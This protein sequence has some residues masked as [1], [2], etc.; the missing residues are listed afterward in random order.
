MSLNNLLNIFSKNSRKD[1]KRP[2]DLAPCGAITVFG[3][4]HGPK[5]SLKAARH[6][7]KSIKKIR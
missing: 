5:E 7:F 2:G 6:I 4:N 1:I 3:H